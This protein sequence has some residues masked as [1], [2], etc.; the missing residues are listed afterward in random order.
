MLAKSN[1]AHNWFDHETMR[2]VTMNTMFEAVEASSL[3]LNMQL[4][5]AFK[6]EC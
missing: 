4:G 1:T 5:I 6:E 2:C 3:V